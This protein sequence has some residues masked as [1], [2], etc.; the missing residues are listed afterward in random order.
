MIEMVEVAPTYLVVTRFGGRVYATME[1][2][3][4]IIKRVDLDDC[5][6]FTRDSKVYEVTDDGIEPLEIHGCWHDDKNPLYIKAT[7]ANGE[8]AFGGYGADH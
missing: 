7:R 6:D 1:T 2:A 8:T 3:G 5:T 4:S